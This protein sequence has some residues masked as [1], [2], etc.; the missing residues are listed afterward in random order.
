MN[1]DEERAN[2]RSSGRGTDTEDELEKLGRQRPEVFARWWSEVGFC[3]AILGSN[4]L[5]EFLVSGFNVLLPVLLEDTGID[6]N[7]KTW[8]STVFSLVTGALLL[9]F[10]RLSDLLGGYPVFVGGLVW[11]VVWSIA[12]G[13]SRTLPILLATR[14][15][16]GI[17]A[18]AYLPAGITLLATTYRPGPRKNVV[19]SLYGGCAP[20]GFFFGIFIAGLSG[21]F[22]Y[23]GWYFW[24]AAMLL[25]LLCG[26]TILCVPR[27]F[28]RVRLT[29]ASI[30]IWGT[31]LS[32]SSLALLTYAITD[33]SHVERGWASPQILAPLI[34]GIITLAAFVY[35]EGWVAENPLL[36]PSLFAIRYTK[37]L[38]LSLFIA[39]GC[40][41]IFLLYAS[42]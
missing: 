38:F 35:V 24:I 16:Q 13:F 20:F 6:S 5:G 29:G 32:V 37:P 7:Q 15:L 21:Q 3:V 30:D 36:P 27:S 40:F 34:A 4:M 9:P 25:A 18:A 26:I 41:G 11:M 10:G 14:A 23:W 42:F 1:G 22:L 17:G 31:V 19:F 33:A 8:P 39:Y 28:N 12:G 2:S